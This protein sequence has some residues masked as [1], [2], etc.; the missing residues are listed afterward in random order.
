MKWLKKSLCSVIVLSLLANMVIVLPI[1][2]AEEPVNLALKKTVTVKRVTSKKDHTKI[3]DGVPYA[4][5]TGS[6]WN[7][8]SDEWAK[9]DLGAETAFNKVMIFEHGSQKA[10][11]YKLEY[12]NDDSTW[13]LIK[14]SGDNEIVCTQRG[15]MSGSNKT[16]NN[17]YGEI[18]FS[19]VT[20]RYFRLTVKKAYDAEA[21]KAA[22]SYISEVELY[23]DDSVSVKPAENSDY[24]VD[25]Q[26]KVISNIPLADNSTAILG[27]LVI[28]EGYTAE[29][30][31][32]G[33]NAVNDGT[34][35]TGFN[36]VLMDSNSK[37]ANEYSIKMGRTETRID[38]GKYN[39][40]DQKGT[41]SEIPHS[42]KLISK[43]TQYLTLPEGATFTLLR[44][45]KPLKDSD[46]LANGDVLLVT[47]EDGETTVRY[48]IAL[49]AFLTSERY[50]ISDEEATITNI[51]FSHRKLEIFQSNLTA[52][53]N[54]SYEIYRNGQRV[55]AGKIETGDIVWV[56]S[57]T[58]GS[59]Q[60]YLVIVN[61]LSSETALNALY[62]QID[63]EKNTIS[64]IPL[65]DI[66]IKTI[67]RKLQ[68]CLP[69]GASMLLLQSNGRDIL[70]GNISVGCQ[71]IVTAEDGAANRTYTITGVE[72]N[73]GKTN[74]ALGKLH[75][76]SS[77]SNDTSFAA[78][79]ALDDDINTKWAPKGSSDDSNP[80]LCIDL[81][82]EQLISK[83]RT[84][85]NPTN[86]DRVKRFEFQYSNTPDDPQS[87]QRICGVDD[88]TGLGGASEKK[89]FVLDTPLKA[90]YIRFYVLERNSSIYI[91][92]LGVYGIEGLP[93]LISEKYIVD[94]DEMKIMDIPQSD[95]SV[96]VFRQNL[97]LSFETAELQVCDS[98]GNSVATGDLAE[99]YTVKISNE[100]ENKV[101]QIQLQQQSPVIESVEIQGENL[102][103]ET[104]KAIA[105]CNDETADILYRWWRSDAANG[106]YQRIEDAQSSQYTIT[107]QDAGKYL[108]ADAIPVSTTESIYGKS[109][110]SITP[111][112]VGELSFG[113]QVTASSETTDCEGIKA[114]DG[115]HSTYWAAARSETEQPEWLT[116]D[117]G[118]EY[119]FN[120][121]QIKFYRSSEIQNYTLS[122]SKNG[123]SWTEIVA[124]TLKD[125]EKDIVFKEISARYIRVSIAAKGKSAGIYEFSV[126][127]S[128]FTAAEREVA[129]AET[130]AYLNKAMGT[131]NSENQLTSDILLPAVGIKTSISWESNT[132][133][134]IKVE[135]GVGKVLRPQ[136]GANKKVTL[137][138]TIMCGNSSQKVRYT[139]QVP[140]VNGT[141]GGNANG[142]GAG[143][144]GGISSSTA[145]SFTVPTQTQTPAVTEP[146]LK[147]IAGSW[148]KPYIETL[149]QDG[150]VS[151]TPDG[152]FEPQRNITREEFLKM[153]ME[154][155]RLKDA[156][157]K[158]D[159]KDVP[160]D[161]W[162]SPYVAAAQKMG[163]VKGDE[164]GFFGIGENISRQ[165][166]AVMACRVAEAAGVSLA[167]GSN[168]IFTDSKEIASY[169]A[170]SI[171][172]L[173]KAGIINGM[174]DG[175]FQPEGFATREQA[176][177]IMCMLYKTNKEGSLET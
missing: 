138:A 133:S 15:E 161:A 92:D 62:Y 101:Y 80:W 47:A 3:T 26:K 129:I 171:A 100:K 78:E 112:P 75:S 155:F 157:A 121:A 41:I 71:L 45:D 10:Y 99:R 82:S 76:V 67:T 64:D 25:G 21:N 28:P 57:S 117:L 104:L 147:D 128:N 151:G 72:T 172:A 32:K 49:E 165:D 60:Q 175:S 150:I 36:L 56:S 141:G 173:F 124:E 43:F 127:N 33:G 40:D 139:Y 125:T 159:F 113:K 146:K 90:R 97:S 130:I 61:G 136:S 68:E 110:M 86:Y 162:F 77:Q 29:I 131:D 168:L 137:T 145:P 132:P 156:S 51:P 48:T 53:E 111:I 12:S 42:D 55:T 1:V 50:T 94:D 88:G 8:K 6:T 38:S 108:K 176:A 13:S 114:I 18:K 144:G 34:V 119:T 39:V 177:K 70:Q 31:D 153:L 35:E 63:N 44:D 17:Y 2:F 58:T 91:A 143:N 89:D 52:G 158:A 93:Y 123:E 107:E 27:N 30:R 134:V 54:M 140:S 122:Y 135:N 20:A 149:L 11:G 84:V 83:L 81:G 95:R 14:E 37:I 167:G 152:Y 46:S 23:F 109:V 5:A 148:A 66:S 24:L 9:I 154:A 105:V 87:W 79:N 16:I 126:R 59:K 106:T 73:E 96:E 169:A 65:T 166:M 74:L 98:E 7:A 120:H 170:D 160:E 4:N 174:E 163:I 103:G 142:G 22:T 85:N 69:D 115:D 118:Q 116:V 102:I 19:A 164:N